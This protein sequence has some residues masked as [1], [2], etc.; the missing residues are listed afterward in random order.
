MLTVFSS[1]I[2]MPIQGYDLCC[3]APGISLMSTQSFPRQVWLLIL[4][5]IVWRP[6]V[7][8]RFV[9]VV[10]P[11]VIVGIAVSAI[12]FSLLAITLARAEQARIRIKR[13]GGR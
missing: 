13:F 10:P 4:I 1:G 8:E 12:F 7:W 3:Y 5:L 11:N 6:H 2:A 9:S